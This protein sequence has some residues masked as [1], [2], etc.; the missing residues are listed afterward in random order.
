MLHRT[1]AGM[2]GAFAVIAVSGCSSTSSGAGAV[3]PPPPGA[4]LIMSREDLA[5]G[6]KLY[7]AKCARCHKFYD[8]AK[9]PTDEWAS[10]MNK[11][12]RKAK[13]QPDQRE[14]LIRYLATYRVASASNG[15][16]GTNGPER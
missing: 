15:R 8:P 4:E 3:P 14:L 6:R 7:V 9:Y 1:M 16:N 10:W 5:S 11:M 12:S 13:L 2:L